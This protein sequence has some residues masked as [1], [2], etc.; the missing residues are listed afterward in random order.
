MPDDFYHYFDT[1]EMGRRNLFVKGW[2]KVP[3]YDPKS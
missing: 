2:P 3:L 1:R